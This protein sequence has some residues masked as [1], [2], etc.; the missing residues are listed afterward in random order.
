MDEHEVF[1]DGFDEFSKMLAE[2]ADKTDPGNVINV[3]EIGAKAFVNDVRALPRPR[4]RM[5]APGYT[6][7]IDTV[8]YQKSKNE[9][10]TG[11]GKYYGPMVENGTVKMDGVP[12]MR[13]AFEK[14]KETYYGKMQ[15]ALFG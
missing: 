4:S 3:L 11:W 2:Y 10:I 9:V 15:K 13:P 1:S 12:H 6:H 14:N 7:L 5:M 8:T